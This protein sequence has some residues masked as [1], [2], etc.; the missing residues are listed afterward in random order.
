MFSWKILVPKQVNKPNYIVL[1]EILWE[2]S[3]TGRIYS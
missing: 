2:I 1:D 3:I